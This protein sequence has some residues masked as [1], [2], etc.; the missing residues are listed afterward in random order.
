MRTLV[1]YYSLTGNTKRTAELVAAEC[2]ADLERIVDLKDRSGAWALFQTGG[3]A[4]FKRSAPIRPT[5]MEPGQYDLVILGTPVWAWTMSSPMRTYIEQHAANF[6]HVA[7]F[8]TEGGTGGQ[9]TFR[10]MTELAGK[11]PIAT[12]E[13]T[14]SDLKTDRDREKTTAFVN[15]VARFSDAALRQTFVAGEGASPE[16]AE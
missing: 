6:K 2:Q 7:F 1:V 4:L 8:C 15:A 5:D 12:L 10:H 11:Q 14:E 9:R 13:I 16:A 3:E